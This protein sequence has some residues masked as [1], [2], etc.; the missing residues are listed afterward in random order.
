[1]KSLDLNV[2]LTFSDSIHTDSDIN[3]IAAKVMSALHIA[4]ESGGGIAPE[5]SD[6]YT[7]HISVSNHV[8]DVKNE[9]YIGF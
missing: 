8:L 6:A 2:S 1:M 3:E 4:I 5:N 7:T 9:A